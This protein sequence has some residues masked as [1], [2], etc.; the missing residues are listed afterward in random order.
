MNHHHITDIAME[1]DK[2]AELKTRLNQ[3][4]SKLRWTELQRHYAGGNVVVVDEALDLI[5]ARMQAVGR[6]AVGIWSGHGNAATNYGTRIGGQ[7][8]RRFAHMYGC[9]QWNPTMICWGLGAF[10]Q[11]LRYLEGKETDLE[12]LAIGRECFGPVLSRPGMSRAGLC[13]GPPRCRHPH[14]S[15]LL[16]V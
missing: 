1:Q 12:L 15:P 10:V 16:G 8:M 6:E 11:G 2:D 4:T 14:Q 13:V 3:E 5:V 7:L 9:Q